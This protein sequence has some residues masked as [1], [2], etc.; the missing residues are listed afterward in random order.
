VELRVPA[1]SLAYWSADAHRWVIESE[2]V[3]IQVGSSSADI[4]ATKTIK[5][6]AAR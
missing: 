2:A 5:L 4:R 6:A 3:R 1:S